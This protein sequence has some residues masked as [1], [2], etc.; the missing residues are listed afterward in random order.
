MKAHRFASHLSDVILRDLRRETVRDIDIL[1]HRKRFLHGEIDEKGLGRIIAQRENVRAKNTEIMRVLEITNTVMVEN[2][3]TFMSN[4]RAIPSVW[5][6]RVLNLITSLDAIREYS[7][8]E[9]KK[10]SVLFKM[11]VPLIVG[12]SPKIVYDTTTNWRGKKDMT[13]SDI[14]VKLTAKQKDMNANQLASL[15]KRPSF[16]VLS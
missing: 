11:T 13:W 6:E 1:A 15:S 3:N 16:R 9:M 14:S 8:A 7:N 10:I 5:G 2:F 12:P 4:E